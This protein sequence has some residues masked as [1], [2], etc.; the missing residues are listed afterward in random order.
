VSND[1]TYLGFLKFEEPDMWGAG[2]VRAATKWW[3]DIMRNLIVVAVLLYLG[4]KTNSWPVTVISYV[5]FGALILYCLTYTTWWFYS[6]LQRFEGR[7]WM[8]RM[9]LSQIANVVALL[10]FWTVWHGLTGAVEA[11]SKAQ[12]N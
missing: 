10:M 4:T 9:L 1:K 3:L 5:S 2:L 7:S 11:I 12:G 8:I 6:P